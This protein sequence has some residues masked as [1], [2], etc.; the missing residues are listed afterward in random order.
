MTSAVPSQLLPTNTTWRMPPPFAIACD[1][2]SSNAAASAATTNASVLRDLSIDLPVLFSRLSQ[3]I[4]TPETIGTPD[5][6][7]AGSI[8]FGGGRFGPEAPAIGCPGP[9]RPAELL[10]RRR[11]QSGLALSSELLN[12]CWSEPSRLTSYRYGPGRGIEPVEWAV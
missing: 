6:L 8:R 3:A 4:R 12:L 7:R 11:C 2:G 1:A 5:G 9:V 10:T